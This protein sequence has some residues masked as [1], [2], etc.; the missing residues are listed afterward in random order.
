VLRSGLAKN[1]GLQAENI[2]FVEL[3]IVRNPIVIFM[4]KIKALKD[5]VMIIIII[6]C[7]F[8]LLFISRVEWIDWSE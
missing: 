4:Q 2:G 8:Y 1:D 7:N 5:T 3:V 6:I